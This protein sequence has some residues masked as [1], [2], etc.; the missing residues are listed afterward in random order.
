[1]FFSIDNFPSVLAADALGKQIDWGITTLPVNDKN[2]KA[3]FQ[4]PSRGN[5]G[6][7]VTAGAKNPEGAW[8]L[9]KFLTLSDAQCSFMTK[10]QGRFST[11]KRCNTTPDLLKRPEFQVFSKAVDSV[12]SLPFSPGDDA[13]IAALEKYG[14]DA[15]LGRT[16]I[17]AAIASAVRD[18][19]N[20][21]DEGWKQWRG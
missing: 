10:D 7:G 2:S 12:V 1:M 14:T 19:Q 15:V 9:T 5:H 4:I 18:A 3:K 6:Y 11:L 21:L 16:G 17:D 20:A 8:A 13:A